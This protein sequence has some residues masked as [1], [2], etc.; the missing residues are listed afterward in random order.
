MPIA[1]SIHDLHEIIIHRLEAKYDLPLPCNINI[2]SIEWI[3]F[4]FWPTNPTSTRAM[5]YTGQFNIKYQIQARQLR[6]NHPDAHY[7]ACLFHYL[8]EFAILYHNYICFIAAD[9]KHKVPIREGV[10]T[11]TGVHNKKSLVSTNTTLAASA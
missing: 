10:A 11:S 8:R 6:K 3:R 7:C 1:I 4:Q 5:H 9:D 2:P